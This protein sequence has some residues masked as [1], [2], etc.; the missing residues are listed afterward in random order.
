MPLTVAGPWNQSAREHE[1]SGSGRFVCIRGSGGIGGA[2][3]MGTAVRRNRDWPLFLP[4][5]STRPPFRS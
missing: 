3:W 1:S 5:Q 2:G 4:F